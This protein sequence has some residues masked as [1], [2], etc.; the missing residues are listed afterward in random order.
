MRNENFS[1]LEAGSFGPIEAVSPETSFIEGEDVFAIQM[2]G[3][4]NQ[5]GVG[6][7]HRSVSMAGHQGNRCFKAGSGKNPAVIRNTGPAT[8][9]GWAIHGRD[10]WAARMCP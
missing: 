4:Q 1:G 8:T 10:L 3:G 5:G 7:I 9:G 2:P 6:E